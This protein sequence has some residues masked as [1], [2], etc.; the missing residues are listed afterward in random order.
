[1][2]NICFKYLKI[3]SILLSVSLINS[4]DRAYVSN[5]LDNT[6]SVVDVATNTVTGVV[7]NG[8][9]VAPSY[10]ALTPNGSKVYVLNG[11]NRVSIIDVATN[12]VTGIVDDGN[13]SFPRGI[14]ITPDGTKAYVSNATN[15][16][17]SII[18]VATDSVTGIVD[19]GNFF[20]PGG[21]ALTSTKAYV[22]N[23]NDTVSIIDIATDTVMG[24][25]DEGNFNTPVGIAITSN[26]TKAYV[27]NLGNN[28]LSIIDIATD[29]VTGI[30]DE[31][32]FNGPSE[33]SFDTNNL[34]AYVTNASGNS[35]SI[36][37]VTTNTVTG[38][39]DEGNF[40]APGG[41]AISG[42]KSYVANVNDTVSIID[43]SI[44]TVTGLVDD[45]NFDGPISIIFIPAADEKP[46]VESTTASTTKNNAVNISV[47]GTDP[48]GCP[49]TF[50]V[51]TDPTHGTVGSFTSTSDFT[52]E[53]T[54]TPDSDYIGTDCFTFQASNGTLSSDPGTINITIS[55]SSG[56]TFVQRL[57]EKYKSRLR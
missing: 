55:N 3:V 56:E 44:D 20:F 54:Y 33:I 16:T 24:I 23:A 45:G 6:V 13:F 36:I 30:V 50:T 26:G 2:K 27:A 41:I 42:T 57:I 49:L 40:N 8:N 9:F 32:N 22:V 38:I 10:M 35:V 14:A 39:V 1:M 17:V 53:I 18:D 19:G 31:G 43:V 51:V 21:I 37:D 4:M 15:S 28:T 48:N 12:T 5:T 34:K 46:K 52:A 47:T 11:D 7:E 29:T 25:V